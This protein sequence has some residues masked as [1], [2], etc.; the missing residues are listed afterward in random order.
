LANSFQDLDG[1]R[2]DVHADPVAGHDRDFHE[3]RKIAWGPLRVL[4]WSP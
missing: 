4:Q 1:L 3:R 2:G